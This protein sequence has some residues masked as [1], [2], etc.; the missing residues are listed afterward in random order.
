MNFSSNGCSLARVA[1]EERIA[2]G[3]VARLHARLLCEHS[4]AENGLT[5]RIGVV[6]PTGE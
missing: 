1:G 6:I 4:S 5:A 2:D 3:N